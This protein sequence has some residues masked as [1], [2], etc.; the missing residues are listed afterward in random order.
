M[1]LSL[2]VLAV[3]FPPLLSLIEANEPQEIAGES[4]RIGMV[5][6]LFRDTPEPLVLAMMQPFGAMMRAQTGLTGKLMPGGDACQLGQ[7][8][9]EDKVQL[10]V[11]HGVEF[12]WARQQHPE[13]RPLMIAVNQDPH[14]QAF[15]VVREGSAVTGFADLKGKV[16]ALP[17]KSREHCHMFLERRCQGCGQEADHFFAKIATPPNTEEAFEDV[18]DGLV[19]A[20]VVDSISL[21][22]YKRRKPARSA[23]LKLVQR[24]EIFP[25][26]VVAY[27]PGVLGEDALTAF[28][29]GMLRANKSALGRQLMTLW[30]LTAFQPVPA[31]YEQTL[32]DI[33]K[34]YPAPI[35]HPK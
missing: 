19:D 16:L 30:K 32:T 15:L 25:A 20:A 28:R 27:H 35:T 8:L 2:A 6:T 21:D 24:S 1:H 9:A 17:R 29:E 12:A 10:A 31:D 4:V 18:V 22:C 13:L 23:Q 33:V 7:L 14:V 11:F 34:A 26:A 5:S 3:L